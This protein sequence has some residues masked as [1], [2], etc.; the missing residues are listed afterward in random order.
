MSDVR[1]FGI[2][3]TDAFRINDCY[4]QLTDF[5]SARPSLPGDYDFWK[6]RAAASPGHEEWVHRVNSRNVAEHLLRQAIMFSNFTLWIRLETVEVPVD[7]YSIKDICHRSLT[8]GAYIPINESQQ[9]LYGRPLWAKTT[10]WFTLF[11]SIVYERYGE[12]IESQKPNLASQT[13]K[14]PPTSTRGPPALPQAKLDQ[15]WAKQGVAIHAQTEIEILNA[16]RAAYPKNH[17]SRDR[18][19]KMI[20]PR[21]RG[22]KAF[23]D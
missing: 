5:L 4:H 17:I 10:D 16:V 21:K 18:V 20:G 12:V 13:V 23:R 11:R 14:P 3:V 22:P 8:A 7:R 19:R 15:W 2:A 6:T 9:Y 1:D